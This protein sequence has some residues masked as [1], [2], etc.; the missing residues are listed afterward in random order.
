[1]KRRGV[2]LMSLSCATVSGSG[3]EFNDGSGV[4]EWGL[5]GGGGQ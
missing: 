5:V 1:M 3:G 2:T 4:G